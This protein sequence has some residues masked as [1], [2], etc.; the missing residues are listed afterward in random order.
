VSPQQYDRYTCGP[1]EIVVAAAT[2]TLRAKIADTL[3]LYNVDWPEPLAQWHLEI[4]E[5]DTISPLGAGEYLLCA[6]MNVE[7]AGSQLLATCPSGAQAVC[8]RNA[9]R[10][11]ILVPRASTDPWVL[12]DLES[13]LSLVLT[14]GWR[15]AGWI[16]LH[17]GAVILNDICALICA[18]SGGGKTSLTAALVRR[19]WQTLGDDK[20]LLRIG[21]D[22]APELRALVHT[23]NLHP[24]TRTWFPEVGNLEQLPTYSDWTEK[25]KVNPETIWPGSTTTEATPSV[26]FHLSGRS[27]NRVA[28]LSAA[29]VLSIL[30]HQTVIPSHA[31]TAR[32]ILATIANAA[33]HLAGF[34]VEI[35]EDAY[36]N[37]EC[38]SPLESALAS[39]LSAAEA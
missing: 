11:T 20:L 10:W 5:S 26:L 15:D 37:P 34:R 9:R 16:P 28:P 29:S 6:R 14:E 25:R 33:P 4:G 21:D 27:E 36:L 19:G 7:L 2:N 35:A 39:T 18:E 1:L 22:G 38:L 32:Q 12:T 23:F 31:P 24:R 3:E 8:D 30:L 13:L 17:S